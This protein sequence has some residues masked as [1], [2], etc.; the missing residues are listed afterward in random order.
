[1]RRVG[2]FILGRPRPLP[3]QRRADH[4]YTLICEEP[5]NVS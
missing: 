3:R 5:E 4:L 1:M 2:T